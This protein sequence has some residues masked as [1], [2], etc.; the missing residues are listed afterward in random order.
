MASRRHETPQ[1]EEPAP[2]GRKG[3]TPN[4]RDCNR[5]DGG[6]RHRS[7]SQLR[8][9]QYRKFRRGTQTPGSRSQTAAIPT[10]C[11]SPFPGA[12]RAAEKSDDAYR[13]PELPA[14]PL[15]WQK[16]EIRTVLKR[17]GASLVG[18]PPASML[19]IWASGQLRIHRRRTLARRAIRD[20]LGA[21][22]LF[23]LRY[24]RYCRHVGRAR[25][26]TPMISQTAPPAD[27][28]ALWWGVSGEVSLTSATFSHH[29]WSQGCLHLLCTQSQGAFRWGVQSL[30][31]SVRQVC[32][33]TTSDQ[34]RV[35]RI[36]WG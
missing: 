7:K 35:R 5:R 1:Q 9:P 32:G 27:S 28:T 4:S 18:R 17:R 6:P 15:Q 10:Q 16:D 13:Y 33:L 25:R 26:K 12:R 29:K 36:R 3:F 31:S 8:N 21:R 14:A 19:W 2:A 34:L 24:T 30:A 11:G 23:A 22:S 20:L